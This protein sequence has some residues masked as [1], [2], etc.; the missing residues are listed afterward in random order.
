MEDLN[1]ERELFEASGICLKETFAN[2]AWDSWKNKYV[3]LEREKKVCDNAIRIN[4][5]FLGWKAAKAQAVPEGYVLVPKELPN[6]LNDQIW[7]EYL[8]P[9]VFNGCDE[10]GYISCEDIDLDRLYQKIVKASESGA[11][12]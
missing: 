2:V 9:L 11:E 6:D 8:T 12:G 10:I 1:K 3:P 5:R 7:D 4:D